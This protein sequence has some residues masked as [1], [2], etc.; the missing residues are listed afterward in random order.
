M[1]AEEQGTAPP[2]WYVEAKDSNGV[3]F[4]VSA[5]ATRAEAEQP[6][7]D[8]ERSEQVPVRIVERPEGQETPVQDDTS[9]AEDLSELDADPFDGAPRRGQ[10][11]PPTH[12][13]GSAR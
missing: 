11:A 1:D 2:R 10:Q 4:V 9:V 6:K 8:F 7:L 5:H 13:S 3:W 12:S